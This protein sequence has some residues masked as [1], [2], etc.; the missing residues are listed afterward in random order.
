MTM[1]VMMNGIGS[2]GGGGGGGG[3]SIGVVVG[4]CGLF[5]V[6]CMQL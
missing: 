4:S 1:A 6:V 5:D 3:P 2:G